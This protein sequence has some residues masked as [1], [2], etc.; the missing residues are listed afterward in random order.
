MTEARDLYLRSAQTLRA[1]GAM[2]ACDNA[3]GQ[4]LR[5]DANHT[6]A[7]LL[8]GQVRLER[9]DAQGA[10]QCLESLPD[11]DSRPDALRILLSAHLRLGKLVEAEPVARKLLYL[12]RC[13]RDHGFCRRLDGGGRIRLRAELLSG[14]RCR[15]IIDQHPATVEA[16]Q[17]MIG[18]L[19]DN[20]K[21][22]QSLQGLFEMAGNSTHSAEV[23][24]LWPMPGSRRR[25]GQGPR[26][27]PKTG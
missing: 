21:A 18:P 22:L 6:Q 15:L 4:V 11:L 10:A 13:H 14:A 5:L 25:T 16:L 7:L 12:R 20:P 2:E 8:R 1:R 24:E 9:G 27:L 17:K 3:L 26:S 23:T 19:K